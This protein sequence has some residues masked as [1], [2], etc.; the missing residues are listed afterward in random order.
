MLDERQKEALTMALDYAKKLTTFPLY[1]KRQHLPVPT[2]PLVIVHGGAGSGK[3]RLISSIH[4]MVADTL[5]KP[6]D[7][8]DCPY[9]LLTSFT[10]AASS[11]INGQT[12]HTT[13]SFKFGTTY[14]S[15]P[16]RTR[17]MKRALFQNV[18]FLIV[19]EISMISADMLFMIDLRL[20]EITGRLDMVFG[21]ISVWLFG[22][23]FQ[24]KPPKAR[25]IFEEPS[26]K[27]H[28][29]AHKLRDLWKMFTVI[30]LEKN[31]RQVGVC[32]TALLKKMNILFE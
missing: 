21:G 5:K 28:A 22:D 17:A 4:N 20:R 9:I 31:H 7:N 23:L 1:S 18:R 29:V 13:F 3:S 24:L 10:G 19:D 32:D 27:E 30:N 14:M 15:L 26:N 16:E 12:L 11:N 8:P 25:Y 6:G 2:A